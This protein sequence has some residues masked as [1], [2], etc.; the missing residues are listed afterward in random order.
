MSLTKT[1]LLFFVLLMVST[2]MPYKKYDL[3]ITKAE[4]TKSIHSPN[5]LTENDNDCFDQKME[6]WFI[7]FNK[8][9]SV[10][11]DMN[12]ADGLAV[13]DAE[14]EYHACKGDVNMQIASLVDEFEIP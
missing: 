7:A 4:A 13:T 10:G 6:T 5:D 2:F 14:N 3:N 11:Y 8:Y 12:R 9:Q 1:T